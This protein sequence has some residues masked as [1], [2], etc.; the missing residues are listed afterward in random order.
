MT[1]HVERL[2]VIESKVEVLED[3]HRELLKLMHEIKDEMTRYKGFLGGIA[4]LTSGVLVF[5]T[6]FKDWF[7]KHL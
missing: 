4:F 7:I 1:D 5:L 6:L 2:A 3:N